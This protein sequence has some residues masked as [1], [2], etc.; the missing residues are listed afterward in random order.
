[1]RALKL[2]G[3][4]YSEQDIASAPAA[5]KGRTEEDAII[6]YMQNLGLALRTTN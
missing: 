1:M 6:A 3:V 4:P 5:V 2:V